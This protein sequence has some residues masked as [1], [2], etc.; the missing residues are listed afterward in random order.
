MTSKEVAMLEMLTRLAKE[1]SKGSTAE[2]Y[3]VSAK[4]CEVFCRDVWYKYGV[5]A[6]DCHARGAERVDMRIDGKDVE[7][8]TGGTVAP[9]VTDS[10]T[11]KD[12]FPRAKYVAFP[13]ITMIESYDEVASWTVVM[14]RETFLN[15]CAACSR[16]GLRGTFH[17]TRGHVLAFQPTPLRKLRE[18]LAEALYNGDL[19]TLETL[20]AERA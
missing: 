12:I 16:K 17:V 19:P 4:A 1:K 13:I 15:Y 3:A 11:E 5:K 7:I 6:N 2:R 18:M 9:Y 8:K 20:K 10:W 14:P